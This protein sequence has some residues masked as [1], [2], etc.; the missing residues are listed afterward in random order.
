MWLQRVSASS[1]VVS[2]VAATTGQTTV[3]HTL[4][5]LRY[6]VINAGGC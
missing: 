3:Q 6:V 2:S 4:L 1:A 5:T